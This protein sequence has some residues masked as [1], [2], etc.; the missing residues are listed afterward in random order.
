MKFVLAVILWWPL[1][2][3]GFHPLRPAFAQTL[4]TRSS[5][6]PQAALLGFSP[7]GDWTFQIEEAPVS[8]PRTQM[9]RWGGWMGVLKEQ[10]VWLGDGSWL[11]GDIS[12]TDSHR[13]VVDSE[14]FKSADISLDSVR[15][16]LLTPPQTL[17]RWLQLQAEM[18]EVSGDRDLL[19]LA[20]N[21]KLSGVIRWPTVTAP[22]VETLQVDTAGQL[23]VLPLNSVEAIVFSPTLVGSLPQRLARQQAGTSFKLGLADG[24]LL[25]VQSF[26]LDATR[27]QLTLEDSSELLTLD[28]PNRF[29]QAVKFIE[30]PASDAIFLSQLEPA[31]YR[32]LSDS[33]LHWELGRDR[34][35]Y[36]QPL[37]TTELQFFRG[38]A[39]HSSS[40][41]AF[42]WDGSGA[43][44]LSEVVFAAPAVQASPSLGS[45]DCQV[46]VARAGKLETVLE[47]S[48]RRHSHGQLESTRIIDVDV[49]GAQLVVLVTEKSDFGQYADH[50]LW[51]D[52]RI[53]K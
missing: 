31:S 6:A 9:V 1:C 13:I 28:T 16:V 44:F 23:I 35:V 27:A 12:F 8:V 5:I 36:H 17:D 19:W 15:G 41:A 42:R 53:A 49:T 11:C 34:D 39:M 24:S 51:L 4:H 29:S 52:A 47:F 46:L 22:R 48:L 14:W 32:H 20:G 37:H 7:E 3:V 50:V 18:L 30:G 26:S 40:Q 10:A 21:K 45:V 38:L 43:R 2:W 25:N 33:V